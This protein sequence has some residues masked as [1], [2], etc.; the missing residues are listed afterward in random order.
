MIYLITYNTELLRNYNPMKE[1]IKRCSI[2]WWHHLKNTWL[3]NTTMNANQI[4]SE[5]SRHILPNDRLLIIQISN[6]SDYQGYLPQEAW[7]W[8]RD[9][10]NQNKPR[11]YN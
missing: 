10:Q 5:L 9:I 3:I 4:Y 2:A 7:D 11:I 8:I 6:T 1:S